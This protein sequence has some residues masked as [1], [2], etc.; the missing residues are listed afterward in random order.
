M[1]HGERMKSMDIFMDKLA[2]RVNAQEMIK[3][4]SEADTARMEELQTQVDRYEAGLQN[5]QDCNTKN[6]ELS[7]TMKTGLNAMLDKME[8]TMQK[9]D[10]SVDR[11][12]DSL[13]KMDDS[14]QRMD[15]FVQKLEESKPQFPTKEELVEMFHQSD[16]F[17]HRE[18]VKVYRNVQASI[19]EENEKQ[20][21]Q[22]EELV[23]AAN[24]KLSKK[25]TVSLVFSILAFVAAAGTLVLEILQILHIF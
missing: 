6:A 18:D 2:Q 25:A 5:M 17:N 20:T 7:E 9:M 13:D 1:I 24:G 14:V 19:V 22:I 15:T 12:D 4:N 3:A 11:M 10:G 21:K 23:Q 8:D 16:D